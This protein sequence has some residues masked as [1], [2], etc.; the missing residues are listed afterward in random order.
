M[1]GGFALWEECWLP[2]REWKGVEKRPRLRDQLAWEGEGGQPG[3]TAGWDQDLGHG[4][5]RGGWGGWGEKKNGLMPR[6][7]L[8]QLG[9]WHE[10]AEHLLYARN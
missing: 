6:F 4:G 2:C 1:A 8:V 7:F 9:E 10:L 3:D 5:W